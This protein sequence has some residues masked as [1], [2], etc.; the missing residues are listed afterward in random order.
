MR[1]VV[2]PRYQSKVI[3]AAGRGFLTGNSVGARPSVGPVRGTPGP[4]Q[5]RSM[6]I[7]SFMS[8]VALAAA[9]IGWL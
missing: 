4:L 6:K 5:H 2:P 1:P 8:A 3:R 9:V 7:E